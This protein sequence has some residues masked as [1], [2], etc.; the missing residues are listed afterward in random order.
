[1][2]S[3]PFALSIF[4]S[5]FLGIIASELTFELPD[6]GKECFYS[7]IKA[8]TSATLEFQV[9]VIGKVVFFTITFLIII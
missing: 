8:N 3:L 2:N 5:A 1:M 9:S 7:E 4:C 6:N